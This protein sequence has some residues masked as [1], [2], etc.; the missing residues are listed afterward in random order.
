LNWKG[1]TAVS[2]IE[3]ASQ[4]ARTSKPNTPVD[5]W[6]DQI[7]D[8][9]SVLSID[10]CFAIALAKII[11]AQTRQENKC[12]GKVSHLGELCL[13]A[14]FARKSVSLLRTELNGPAGGKHSHAKPQR[15]QPPNTPVG[16]SLVLI[17]SLE[18]TLSGPAC[19]A[20]RPA[21]PTMLD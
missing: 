17:T 4:K 1:A 10:P 9:E 19:F 5:D 18:S 3:F 15:T 14:S 13:F 2:Q 16:R 12:F 7:T 11:L 20:K 21:P 6:S 8:S